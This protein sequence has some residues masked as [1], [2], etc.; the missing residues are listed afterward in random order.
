[1]SAG[2]RD[3]LADDLRGFGP[4]GIASIIAI[5]LGNALF[6]PLSALLAVAWAHRSD[7]PLAELGFRRP[8]RWL[9]TLLLGLVLG[10]ALKLFC[11]AI[12]LPLLNTDPV[13]H[14]YHGLTGNK[15]A[16]PGTLYLLVIGAGFGEEVLFRG[17]LFE[18]LGRRFGHHLPAQLSTLLIT[19]A[20][21]AAAH[22][23]DQGVPGAEQAMLTGLVFGVL[24]LATGSLA[25]PM[26]AHTAFDLLAYG[27]V[28]FD[29]ET[30][31]A[32]LVFH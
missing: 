15:E 25:L 24:Y 31:V 19:S 22:L 5:L 12:L 30:R 11:K 1:V 7:T 10:V 2:H 16:I 4:V 21:F 27:I 6:P 23:H 13:N 17:Y 9:L 8:R 29:A 20:L 14:A 18:R 32:H 3:R 26:V 28:Y